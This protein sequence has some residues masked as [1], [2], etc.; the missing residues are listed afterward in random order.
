MKPIVR[1]R[2]HSRRRFL[3]GG[4]AALVAPLL[5]DC[6]R[7]VLP[8][9]PPL[10]ELEPI[11]P[12][13]A[14]YVT[15]YNTTPTVDP[16]SWQLAFKDDGTVL[17]TVD[18]AFLEDLIAQ[19]VARDKE[20]TL[21]CIGSSPGNRAI[22]NAVWTGLPLP[23]LLDLLGIAFRDDALELKFTG[24]DQY[25]TSLPRADLD[26]PMWLVWRMNGE[27]LPA[28]HGFPAR[29]LSPGRYG[30][31]NPKWI[32]AIELVDEPFLGFWENR[33]WSDDATYLPN[34]FIMSPLQGST[35][36]SPATILGTAFAG[37][38]EIAKVEVS[39][40]GGESWEDA[41]ITYQNGPDIWTLWRYDWDAEP[42]DHQIRVRVTTVSGGT[43]TPDPNGTDYSHGY[44]G[45]MAITV[46][47]V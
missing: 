12:N 24:A 4:A 11:T 16:D 44:D 30:T 13:D 27:P 26:R 28:H 46:T 42:G 21:Q 1:F 6:D 19:G 32:T 2:V 29:I 3:V 33:G 7:L 23:E 22:G 8:D 35:E 15:T 37:S 41:E 45:G 5:A 39:I 10:D 34:G 43:S 14:F 31:K 9:G 20:H 18:L 25:E 47:F 36:T 38:D 40:D 17:G